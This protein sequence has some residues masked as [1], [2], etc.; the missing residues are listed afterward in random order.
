MIDLANGTNKVD[1]YNLTGVMIPT[2]DLETISNT[3][4]FL[5]KYFE[6][7]KARNDSNHANKEALCK[8]TTARELREEIKRCVDLAR[9]LSRNK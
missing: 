1:L 4:L 8:Y 7:K 2:G 9:L 6:I 3:L 5:D